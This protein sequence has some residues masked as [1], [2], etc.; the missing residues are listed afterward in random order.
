[1]KIRPSDGA[2]S[3]LTDLYQL[4]MAHGYW[5]LG[6]AQQESVFHLFFRKNP[7]GGGFTVAAGLEGACE[8]LE[9]L[10]YGPSDIAWLRTLV[11]RDGG[12]LFD[13]EFLE[14]LA[15]LQFSCDVDAVPEGTP[16]FPH[17][18]LLR[19]QGPLWQ[20]QLLETPLLTLINFESLIAT[21]AAR[22]C[23]AAGDKPVLEFGLRRAQGFDGGMSA[24]RAA[25]LG[26]CVGTSNCLAGKRYGIPVKGTHAHS[27]IMSFD[28][29]IEAFAAYA[30]AMPNNCTFL[31]DTYDTLRGVDRAI[32]VARA[33]RAR[34]HEM[35]GIRLDSGDLA[36]L[37]IAARAR[38]DTAGFPDAAIVAS[39]DLDEYRIR[40]LEAA[41]AQI[42]A[43]GVGTRLA[44]AFDQPA[45]GGVFKLAAL[46]SS[47]G[48]WQPKLKLS[49]DPIKVSVPGSQGV[50]RYQLDGRPVADLIYDR[51][52]GVSGDPRPETLSGEPL[53]LPASADHR[54]L[55]VP[56]FR[57]GSRVRPSIPLAEIRA[58]C[59]EQVRALGPE[60][61]EL[62]GPA[63]YPVGL[64][65]RIADTR[66]ALMESARP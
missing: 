1:M 36:K 32:E 34:G 44:T 64:E 42:S 13:P 4:T 19:I 2:A 17:T 12:P 22:I 26:G 37:S 62:E 23:L 5:K 24:S 60:L 21:K 55:L 8:F 54:E 56:I 20:C 38:L 43:W 14:D 48:A 28:E 6:R 7:F 45:L 59:I 50:R 16:C 10:L 25:Y 47:D 11:G 29:E 40:E 61:R 65:R 33:L 18:P 63:I 53:V 15:Q 31:V 46:R 41:G 27:W 39:N 3:L 49:E 51:E 57:A 30:E 35:A 52:L 66:R 9:A 58:H